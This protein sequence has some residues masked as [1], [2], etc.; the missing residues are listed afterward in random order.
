MEK[1]YCLT[2]EEHFELAGSGNG[3]FSGPG[4]YYFDED[5]DQWRYYPASQVERQAAMMMH[6]R[7]HYNGVVFQLV[8]RFKAD[9]EIGTLT[10]SGKS[11]GETVAR[12][13]FYHLHDRRDVRE[14]KLMNLTRIGILYGWRD[15]EALP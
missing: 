13:L 12:N 8:I 15:G 2:K 14:I 5:K 11:A 9:G 3:F 10:C 6:L 7:E 4:F 1:Q